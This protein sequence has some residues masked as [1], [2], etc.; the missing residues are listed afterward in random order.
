MNR[1][2]PLT[3]LICLLLFLAACASQPE[4][5]AVG[6]TAVQVQRLNGDTAVG[7]P[8]LS[9][10]LF[11]GPQPL[12][13]VEAVSIS[14]TPLDGQTG[15]PV[16]IDEPVTAT[17]VS[18]A[19]YDIPYWVAYPELPTPGVWGVTTHIEMSDGTEQTAQFLLDVKADSPSVAVGE[20]APPSQNRT[21]A[22][23]PD[24]SKLSSGNDPNPAL[25]QMTVA[26]AINSGKPTVVAIATPG[27][28]QTKWCA[29]VVDSVETVYDEVGNGANFIHVEVYDDFQ[30]LILTPQVAEWGL[31]TEPWVFVLDGDGR[32][33]ARFEGPL[34][35]RELTA[36]LQP[37]LP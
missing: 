15:E 11:D 7:S 23:E 29:P 5:T 31:A 20:T 17:A 25:Y 9:F 6:V 13:G 28:C 26:E 8:R 34:S 27:L 10:T 37:L 2:I 22:T 36:A 14:A 33:M 19:D 3:I 16:T 4:P 18:Y 35:P 24:I 12:A 21:L 30:K 1:T 32:V